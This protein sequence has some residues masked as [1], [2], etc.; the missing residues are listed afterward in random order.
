MSTHA[1]RLSRFGLLTISLTWRPKHERS[2]S[3]GARTRA[4]VPQIAEV[5]EAAAKT[6]S[7]GAQPTPTP[8]Q[9]PRLGAVCDER[10][11]LE[12]RDPRTMSRGELSEMGH[13]TMSPLQAIRAH[14]LNCCGGSSREVAECMAV[15]C[16]SWPFRMGSNPWRAPRSDEQRQAIGIAS[17]SRRGKQK[18]A[19][20]RGRPWGGYHPIRGGNCRRSVDIRRCLKTQPLSDQDVCH[21]RQMVWPR[22][23]RR[24]CPPSCAQRQPKR[25]RR[26]PLTKANK[27]LSPA[28]G[29]PWRALPVPGGRPGENS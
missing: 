22:R 8:K 26:R 6:V 2:T 12:G 29:R 24:V 4:G 16:P 18:S 11:Y 25:E 17:P 27:N 23:R 9:A 1:E 21:R 3:L 20:Q 14:C 5:R 7:I 10:G 13:R 15:R 28:R 19:L